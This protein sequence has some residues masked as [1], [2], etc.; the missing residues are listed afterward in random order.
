MADGSFRKQTRQFNILELNSQK[1]LNGKIKVQV[2]D[3][4]Y[5]AK[6]NTIC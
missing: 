2:L 3:K 5:A 1:F 6:C 4:V